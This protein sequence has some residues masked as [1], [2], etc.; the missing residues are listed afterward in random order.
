MIVF[1]VEN[2]RQKYGGKASR[3]YLVR[4]RKLALSVPLVNDSR[5]ARRIKHTLPPSTW[6]IGFPAWRTIARR[7]TFVFRLYAVIMAELK[8]KLAYRSR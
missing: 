3:L 2:M 1:N 4:T 8:F 6:S 5:E 7:S